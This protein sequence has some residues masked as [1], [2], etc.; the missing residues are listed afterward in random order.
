MNRPNW[1]EYLMAM[2]CLASCRS[3]D[4]STKHGA[5][6]VDQYY[7]CLG[8]GYNSFPRGGKED[9]YPRTRPGKYLMVIHS[10]DNAISNCADRP[11][12]GTLYV[13][14]MPCPHCMSKIIQAGIQRVV[15]GYISS[16]MV[17][18]KEENW[19]RKMAINHD[20]EMVEYNGRSPQ[21]VMQIAANYLDCKWSRIQKNKPPLVVR[22][23]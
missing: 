1:D 4:P 12:G 21:E 14:G 5:V 23:S 8:I 20:I 3:L 17:G 11:E 13:T 7:R 22:K 18:S 9:I 15:Y 10:E 16:I 19:T 2:A 6:I